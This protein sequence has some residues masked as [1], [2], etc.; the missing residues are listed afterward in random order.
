MLT[1]CFAN[2]FNALLYYNDKLKK[3]KKITFIS[4]LHSHKDTSIHLEIKFKIVSLLL[5]FILYLFLIY[6]ALHNFL[7]RHLIKLTLAE[8]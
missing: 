2:L 8:N 1:L 5:F 4:R 7:Q 6:T 3:K